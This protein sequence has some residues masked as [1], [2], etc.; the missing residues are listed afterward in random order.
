MTDAF[1][2]C[3]GCT[4]A[5][6]ADAMALHWR[7]VTGFGD[8]HVLLCPDCQDARDEEGAADAGD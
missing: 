8:E 4:T 6:P 2:T 1:S 7:H 5:I 3:A